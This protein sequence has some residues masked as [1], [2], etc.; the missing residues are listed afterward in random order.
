[1]LVYGLGQA[2]IPELCQDKSGSVLPFAI[3]WNQFYVSLVHVS[4]THHNSLPSPVFSPLFLAFSLLF[5]LFCVS[6]K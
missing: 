5:R 4:S 2:F 3:T 6:L 1:M